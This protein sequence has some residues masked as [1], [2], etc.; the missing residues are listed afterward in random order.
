MLRILQVVTD[1]SWPG[2]DHVYICKLLEHLVRQHR[3]EFTFHVA[4]IR[5]HAGSENTHYYEL[6][7][8]LG[9][10]VHTIEPLHY[11]ELA[12]QMPTFIRQLTQNLNIDVVHSHIFVADL[13]VTI[14]KIGSAAALSHLEHEFTQDDWEV[15][16]KIIGSEVHELNR[17]YLDILPTSSKKSNFSLAGSSFRHISTKHLGVV[18]SICHE[19]DIERLFDG[20]S[21]AKDRAHKINQQ[22]QVVVSQLSDGVVAI[23]QDALSK[24]Q[25]INPKT[26]YI[27]V[28]VI[29]ELDFAATASLSVRRSELRKK[30]DIPDQGTHYLF[31]GRLVRKK[32]PDALVRAFT[33]HIKQF[34]KDTLTIVGG[35]TLLQ[36]CKRWGESSPNIR[37]MPHLNR[38]DVFSLMAS[39]D[40]LCL[41]SLEEGL[42]LVIQEAMASSMPILSSHAGAIPDLVTHGS[43]GF[44]ISDV[45]DRS[46]SDSLARF[47]ALPPEQQR[48]TG[49][50][51]RRRIETW[52]AAEQAFENYAHLYRELAGEPI[53]A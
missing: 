38:D 30:W 11:T 3:E 47:S 15:V 29:D 6:M 5:D 18:K 40:A 4:Q 21:D 39:L 1:L 9:I 44:L 53:R 13:A 19:H 2:G 33:A 48:A 37:F 7:K 34:P 49:K 27:P 25:K 16:R 24:W 50:A 23:G 14:A 22:L 8:D 31:V 28:T 26:K 20:S 52:G 10:K 35:G 17:I 46:I 36:E 42:P 12:F 51:A 43:S 41:F 45:T 32:S